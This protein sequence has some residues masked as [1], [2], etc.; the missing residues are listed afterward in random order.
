MHRLVT[1]YIFVYCKTAVEKYTF[2]LVWK[3]HQEIIQL[4]AICFSLKL[5][6]IENYFNTINI[7]LLRISIFCLTMLNHCIFKFANKEILIEI[8]LGGQFSAV[9]LLTEQDQTQPIRKISYSFICNAWHCCLQSSI[10]K[11]AMVLRKISCLFC[12]QNFSLS[13][14]EQKM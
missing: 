8:N 2:C 6:H 3:R 5:A 13:C 4:S 12:I 11:S 1:K 7:S 14:T 10:Q 9:Q